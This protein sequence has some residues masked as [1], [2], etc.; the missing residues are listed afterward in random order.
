MDLTVKH[1]LIQGSDEAFLV[2]H[3]SK[4]ER[5]QTRALQFQT[6]VLQDGCRDC[7]GTSCTSKM[8]PNTLENELNMTEFV[9]KCLI[10]HL[11]PRLK[12]VA[13]E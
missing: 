10:F 7:F 9:S 3:P 1:M 6:N 4:A 12:G 2:L 11:I 8:T 5:H 13:V